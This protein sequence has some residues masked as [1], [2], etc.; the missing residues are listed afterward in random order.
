MKILITGGSGFIGSH[1]VEFLQFP[2]IEIIILDENIPN[3]D[4]KLNYTFIKGSVVNRELVAHALK[5]VDYVFHLA[6]KISV[7]ESMTEP[8]KYYETNT[9]G[10]IILLEEA[11]KA[12][13]K[14][15]VFASSSAN[16]GSGL[17]I[18]KTEE[19]LLEPKCPYAFTKIDGEYLCEMFRQDRGFKTTSLRFFNVYGERQN[20][21]AQYAAAVPKFVTQCLNN[22]DITLFGGQQTRDFIYVKDI[23]KG[24]VF[25]VLNNIQGVYNLGTGTNISIEKLAI[26]IQKLTKSKSKI[27]YLPERAGD[28]L[29]GLACIKKLKERGFKLD[30]TLEEGVKRVIE[31][32]TKNM[33]DII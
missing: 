19:M 7:P 13:V 26:L 29:V 28:V 21:N 31:Y 27:N 14:H 2:D 33:N 20:P 22:E 4:I 5:G 25:V 8:L 24:M 3:F 12:N 10:T 15:L 23:V 11:E 32:L 30:Y 6:A 1:L 17:K 16:Y 9:K 18:P